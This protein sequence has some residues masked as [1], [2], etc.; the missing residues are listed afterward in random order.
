[1]NDRIYFVSQYDGEIHN[2][3]DVDNI[4]LNNGKGAEVGKWVM[5]GNEKAL[6]VDEEVDL[7]TLKEIYEFYK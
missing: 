4:I 1:M 3:N 2:I 7:C 5:D 6:R